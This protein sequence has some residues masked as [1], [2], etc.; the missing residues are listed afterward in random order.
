MVGSHLIDYLME[1]GDSVIC[2]DNFFTG[3]KDNIRHHIGRANERIVPHTVCA[4][5][6]ARGQY[7]GDMLAKSAPG[8]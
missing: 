5:G 6:H 1:R 7:G 2:V 4:D 8:A 3:S